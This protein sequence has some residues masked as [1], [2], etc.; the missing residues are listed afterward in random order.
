MPRAA[1]IVFPSMPYHIIS[2]R[3]NQEPV[4]Q[5]EED[6]E[7]YLEIYRRYKETEALKW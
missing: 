6:F 7:K 5:N 1:R 2:R 4:L 3:S